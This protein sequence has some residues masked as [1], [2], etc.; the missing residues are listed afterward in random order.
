MNNWQFVSFVILIISA[1]FLTSILK[2]IA[3]LIFKIT[4]DNEPVFVRFFGQSMRMFL[5]FM[6]IDYGSH[7]LGLSLNAKA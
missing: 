4:V 7:Y 1:W 3:P 6:I 5:F 2:R